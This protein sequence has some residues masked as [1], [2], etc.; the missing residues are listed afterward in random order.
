MTTSR[1]RNR[2]VGES[3]FVNIDFQHRLIPGQTLLSVV[4]TPEA[5]VTEDPATSAVTDEIASARF[6]TPSVGTFTVQATVTTQDPTE[7]K[8]EHVTL[9]V[10]VVPT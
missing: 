10:E 2:F 5:P 8:I 1:I 6:T 4:W 9:V 7:T 3:E